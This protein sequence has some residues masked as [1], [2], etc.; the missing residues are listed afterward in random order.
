M[1][2]PRECGFTTEID[3][4]AAVHVKKFAPRY[5]GAEDPS[6]MLFALVGVIGLHPSP[7]IAASRAFAS[8]LAAA[9]AS[10]TCT[11]EGP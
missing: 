3:H 8:G 4:I 9:Y 7:A 11:W 5:A 6:F 2:K 1:G 10:L